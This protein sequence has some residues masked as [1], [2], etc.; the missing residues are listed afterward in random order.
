MSRTGTLAQYAEELADS[1]RVYRLS[2]FQGVELRLNLEQMR[3][4]EEVLAIAR[5][6]DALRDELARG[7]RDL[8]GVKLRVRATRRLVMCLGL[9]ALFCLIWAFAVSGVL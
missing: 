6:Q 8:D 2:G 3:Q 9:L 4:L 1:L 5:K 7:L